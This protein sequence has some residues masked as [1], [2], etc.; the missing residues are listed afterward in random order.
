[1][2]G[3]FTYNAQVPAG[4]QAYFPFGIV[5]LAVAQHVPYFNE[6][7]RPTCDQAPTHVRTNI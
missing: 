1:M 6:F 3:V 7:I 5:T 2:G 4:D